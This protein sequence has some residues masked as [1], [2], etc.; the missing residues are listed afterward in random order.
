MTIA[1]EQTHMA[2]GSSAGWSARDR[3]GSG[4]LRIFL[5]LVVTV[6]ALILVTLVRPHTRDGFI[7]QLGKNCGLVAFIILALQVVLA[8]RF[9]WIERPFGLD[10]VFRF[11][12]VAGV[13]ALCLILL[14]VALVSW[15]S[16]HWYLLTSLHVR[17]QVW[18][19][20]VALL[21]LLTT[22]TI[23]VLRRKWNIEFESWRT[24]HNVL[25]VVILSVGFVHSFS[26]GG[27][28]RVPAMQ[29]Y[30]VAALI[31]A[32]TAYLLHKVARP[33]RLQ[34]N[35]YI[36]TAVRQ[37]APR[38]W[39]IHLE[40]PAGQCVYPYAPGQFHYVTFRRGRGLP[41][42]EHVW[43][44]SSTPTRPGIAS[45]IKEVGDF[46]STIG[47]TQVGDWADL[48][49]PYGRCSYLFYPKEDELVFICGGIGVTPFLAM[50][51]HMHD[52]GARKKVLLLWSNRTEEELVAR[53]E[54]DQIAASGRPQLK[55]V[56]FL[57][58]PGPDWQ[59]ERG[60]ISKEAI[61]KYL[62]PQARAP[63]GAY[64]CCPP[65]MTRVIIRALQDLGIPPHRI[66]DE[67]FSL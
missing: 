29:I 40:P 15:G 3:M 65:P 11:H 66:H 62:E 46:T 19:G 24:L 1:T 13:M 7:Y 55:I 25:A 59:G 9:K 8:A 10:M 30:W 60:R 41:V 28:L 53:Q 38:I 47:Q 17:W 67:G 61:A 27:D 36:V 52:T 48:D 33:V 22:V 23:S 31:G 64:V 35:P 50:L 58:K 39:T 4:F 6:F 20:R 2:T 32:G 63:R 26:M 37:E 16:G 57:T 21:A 49:G 56:L 44:I 51:R 54:L 42:E 34:R 18:L 43:T 14:H 45:T 5:Y 12:R